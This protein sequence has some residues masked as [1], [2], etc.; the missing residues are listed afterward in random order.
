MI[1]SALTEIGIFLI[2]FAVYVL[3]LVAT[4][5]GSLAF[6]SWPAAVVGRLLVASLLLVILSL[7][8]LAQF[9]GAPPNSTYIPAHLENGRLVPGVEK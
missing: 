4:R 3:F 8:L 1:R 2:P 6:S 5:S 9:S 7:I